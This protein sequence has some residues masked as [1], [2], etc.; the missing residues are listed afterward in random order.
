MILDELRGQMDSKLIPWA[1]VQGLEALPA[2]ALEEPPAGIEGDVAC[3]LALLLAK[4]L[5]KSP[6]A[7]AEDLKK[8]L[9]GSL[10]LVDQM[11]VAGAGFLNFTWS[12]KTL[13]AELGVILK[14]SST[15]GRRSTSGEKIL[16]E[17]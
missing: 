13:Q 12:L 11:V 8:H 14:E 16:I 17:F 10:P 2:F 7:I 3:N 5:K 15:Y 4:P 9:Q 6:R 1:K